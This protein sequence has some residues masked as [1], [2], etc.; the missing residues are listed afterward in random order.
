MYCKPTPY[1]RK[2]QVLYRFFL[3]NIVYLFFAGSPAEKEKRQMF[4]F[5]D[6]K[7]KKVF[8]WIIVVILILAMVVPTAYSLIAAL[9]G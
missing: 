7:K 5:R 3:R 6:K 8:I 2:L 1:I 4:D 9:A